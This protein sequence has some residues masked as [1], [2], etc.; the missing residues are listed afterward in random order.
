MPPVLTVWYS[1]LC[2]IAAANIGLWIWS[3]RLLAARGGRIPDETLRL[4]RA[5][6]WLSAGYVAGCAFR[7][8]LPM[9]DEPRICL[10]DG[11]LSRIAVGRTFATIAELCFV[12]QW[13]LLLRDAGSKLGLSLARPV[14]ATLLVLAIAAE[15]FS[16]L[17]V[18]SRNNL[19]HAVENSLWTLGAALVLYVALALRGAVDD[20]SRR[21]LTAA[22]AG[23]VAYLAFMIFVDVPMY[24]ERWYAG[25]SAGFTGQ[26]LADGWAQIVARCRVVRDLAAWRADIPWLTL[27]FSVAVW[28]SIALARGAP[29]RPGGPRGSRVNRQALELR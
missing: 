28:V 26:P 16:W 15:T 12:A 8:V 6:L 2:A 18:L 20:S 19:L 7:S 24:L 3:A 1:G 21:I 29:L 22:A 10:H 17:A 23:I 4:R 5:L 13:A 14:A 11:V 27:Y 25:V 9:L